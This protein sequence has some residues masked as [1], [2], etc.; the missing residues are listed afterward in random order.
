VLLPTRPLLL[1]GFDLSGTA[2]QY[3][4]QKEQ[5]VKPPAPTQQQAQPLWVNSSLDRDL[6]RTIAVVGFDQKPDPKYDGPRKPVE[7]EQFTGTRPQRLLPEFSHTEADFY[8][9]PAKKDKP[10]DLSG[11]KGR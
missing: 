2:Q 1:G 11:R 4:Q 7:V 6:R 3:Q 10:A 5:P 8:V 9:G